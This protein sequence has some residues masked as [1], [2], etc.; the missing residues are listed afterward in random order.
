LITDLSVVAASGGVVGHDYSLHFP[1]LLTG[2]YWFR[3]NGLFAIPWFSPSQCAGFPFFPDPNVL[4]F[5]VPQFLVFL[6]SPMTSVQITSGLFALIALFGTYWLMRRAFLASRSAACL[7]AGLFLFNGFYISRILVGHLTF[8]P[9]ALAP[10]LLVAILPAGARSYG[11]P[12]FVALRICIAAA[13]LAYMLQSGMVHGIP[14]VLIAAV[15]LILV[16][17]LLFGQQW[18]SWLLLAAGGGVALLLCAGKLVSELAL[19]SNFPRDSYPLPGIPSL[20]NTVRMV[21]EIVFFSVPA[22]APDAIVNSPWLLERHEWDYGISA[23]PLVLM[24]VALTQS[25]LRTFRGKAT[26]PKADHVPAIAEI[27]ALLAIPVF[28]NWF[29]PDWNAF[30]KS[31]PYFGNSSNLVRFFS[32]YILVAVVLGGLALDG[33]RL[34]PSLAPP[35][36][37][38]LAAAALG[39]MLYQQLAVN[40][41]MDVGDGYGI[42]PIESAYL[43]AHTTGEIPDITTVATPADA[44][45]AGNDAMVDGRSQG[46]CY[47]PLFGY[48]LEKFPIGP[49]QIGPMIRPIGDVLN[50]KNP[51]CY[52]YPAENACKSGDHFTTAQ[53]KEAELFLSYRPFA[54]EMPLRQKIA[55]WLSLIALFGVLATSIGVATVQI[56]AR[57]VTG[58]AAATALPSGSPMP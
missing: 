46:I 32:T 57:A 49:L 10:I 44:Q 54:F 11:S 14:P 23:A 29:Q 31:L 50:T 28:L 2:Y 51:A 37:V 21:V 16:H 12:G 34:S 5:S 26:R 3:R 58:L 35:G 22:N 27:A 52:L 9:F 43:R 55:D 6:V 20:F 39:L 41:S 56:V 4:Y 15:V 8:H 30:L 18:Q 45:A 25:A 33:I 38:M 24:A 48:R 1:N 13:C 19:L 17:G 53:V 40:R 36:R 7:C 42:L 47:Q